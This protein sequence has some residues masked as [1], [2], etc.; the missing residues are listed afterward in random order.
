[1][2]V[3]WMTATLAATLALGAANAAEHTLTLDPAK[4]KVAWTL[5]AT[6]HDVHGNFALKAAEVRFDP[7]TGAASGEIVVD[8]TVAETGS[9]SRDKTMHNDVLETSKYPTAVF[10]AQKV[11]GTFQPQGTSELVL[12]G[13][14]SFHGADHPFK[15]P[16]KVTAAGPRLT[17]DVAFEI[18]FVSWG[19]HDPSVLFLRVGKSVDVQVVA[20]GTLAV[21]ATAAAAPRR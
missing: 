7:E 4:T 19:L 10:K 1:M 17:A 12:E 18:P 13:T 5:D 21:A 8:L 11:T 20:E 6:G 14:L 3:R 16:A 2:N 15:L 9:K